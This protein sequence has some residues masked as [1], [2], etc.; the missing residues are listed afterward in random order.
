MPFSQGK[1]LFISVLFLSLPKT[2]FQ[3]PELVWG[4]GANPLQY[5][6]DHSSQTIFRFAE[7]EAIAVMTMLVSKYKIEIKE[8]PEFA[9]ET[10]EER[11]ARITAFDQ[12]LTLT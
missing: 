8:E 11:Y 10:F 7:I 2:I 1:F 9:G 5:N 6:R 12:A 4:D 3:V